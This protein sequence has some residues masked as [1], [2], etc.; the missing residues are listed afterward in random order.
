MLRDELRNL[1]ITKYIKPTYRKTE[2]YAG[3]EIEMPIVNLNKEAVDFSKIHMLILDFLK[4]FSF[5]ISAKDEDG[6]IYAIHNKEF[7]DIITFDCSYNNLEIALGKSNN[8]TVTWDRLTK[9]YKYI[10]LWLKTYNY[11]LTGM[12][13]NPYRKYNNNVPIPNERYRMLFHHLCTYKNYENYMLFHKRPDFGMYSSASQVQIDVEY[14][15]IART[16]NVFSKLE[17]IKAILF[18]NSVLNGEEEDLLC[19]RDMLWA[20][21]MQG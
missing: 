11:T 12:G 19:A 4:E 9:Y 14:D 1:L 17:P 3:I 15:D 7:D 21:G 20:N 18:S 2:K 5:E 6:N 10:N 13:I 16:I 8:L